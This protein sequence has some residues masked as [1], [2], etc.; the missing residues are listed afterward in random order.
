MGQLQ[1]EAVGLVR[2]RE[3]ADFLVVSMSG[4]KGTG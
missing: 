2:V 1:G 4:N 3:T